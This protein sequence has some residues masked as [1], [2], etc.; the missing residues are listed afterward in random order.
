MHNLCELMSN[1]LV[2]H[3]VLSFPNCTHVN[4]I[5][6]RPGSMWCGDGHTQEDFERYLDLIS[7]FN[8]KVV[9]QASS[10]FGVCFYR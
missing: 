4:V 5:F 10:R 7:E 9:I 3:V 2:A 1:I 6:I 8:L